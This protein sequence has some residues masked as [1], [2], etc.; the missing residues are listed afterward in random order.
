MTAEQAALIRKSTAGAE[1]YPAAG[2]IDAAPASEPVAA[3]GGNLLWPEGVLLALALGVAGVFLIRPLR[4]AAR[5]AT[6]GSRRRARAA[7]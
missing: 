1:P 5:T 6:P 2:L 4:A 3:D 7:P